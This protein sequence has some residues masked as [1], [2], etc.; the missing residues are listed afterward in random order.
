MSNAWDEKGYLVTLTT[1]TKDVL[2]TIQN[3]IYSDARFFSG[4]GTVFFKDVFLS[5]RGPNKELDTNGGQRQSIP[6]LRYPPF[7]Q[8]KTAWQK[9]NTL[10]DDIRKVV[11]VLAN[12]PNS[13]VVLRHGSIIR[14]QPLPIGQMRKSQDLHTDVDVGD[15]GPKVYG[16]IVPLDHNGISI[17]VSK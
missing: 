11:Q 13:H 14:D 4:H 9:M 15:K 2:S 17:L 6:I 5:A 16:V 1:A 10:K 3:K 8:D 7:S 12:K